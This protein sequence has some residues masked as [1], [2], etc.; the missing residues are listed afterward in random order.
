MARLN[1]EALDQ[2][3]QNI[4]TAM[5]QLLSGEIPADG[6]C[7]LKTLAIMAGVVR[8]GFYPKATRPGP[9][10]H[11]AEEFQRRLELLQRTGAI[12]D[13]RAAQVDRLKHH[14]EKQAKH[15]AASNVTITEMTAF[16]TMA[17]SR[18]AAQHDEIERLRASATR[19]T[20]LRRL[21]SRT[22]DGLIGPC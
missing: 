17:I 11:L 4:R 22:S 15:I 14:N 9:Y 5:E 12:P 13:P 20:N 16:K 3:R 19:P 1:S 2:N 10:Q 18:L 6:K 21:P 7:D 8:T